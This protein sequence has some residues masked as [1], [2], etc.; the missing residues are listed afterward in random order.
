MLERSGMNPMGSAGSTGALEGSFEVQG[1]EA[2]G[3]VGER[4]LARLRRLP[5]RP[6][7]LIRAAARVKLD[8]PDPFSVSPPRAIGADGIDRAVGFPERRGVLVDELGH[9]A[10]FLGQKRRAAASRP[11][12]GRLE[13]RQEVVQ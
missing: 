2:V 9:G 3:P 10:S 4:L 8:P 13:N 12:L 11:R 1:L 5:S 7:N 6:A